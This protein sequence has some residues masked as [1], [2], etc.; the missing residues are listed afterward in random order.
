MENSII[1][2]IGDELL[3]G[4]TVDTNS[5]WI[6]TQMSKI[7][8]PVLTKY[9]VSD[10]REAITNAILE[11]QKHCD[12]IILTGGLGPTRDDITKNVLADYFNVD[13]VFN[14]EAWEIINNYFAGRKRI[15]SDLHRKQ[16]YLPANANLLEN[17]VGT[18]PGMMFEERGKLI[19]S[20]P[21]VPYEMEYIMKNSVLPLLGSRAVKT[22]IHKTIRTFGLPEST[23]AESITHIED[24]LPSGMGIAYLPSLGEVKLRISYSGQ[25]G[26]ELNTGLEKV[27]QDIEHILGDAVY[28]YDDDSLEVVVSDILH[29]GKLNLSLAESCTGGTL[30]SRIVALSGSAEIFEGGFVTYSNEMKEKILGVSKESLEQYGAVSEQV[31]SEM[32][33]GLLKLTGT[34][35][36]ISITGIAGPS[37]GSEHK[38]V[39]TVFIGVGTKERKEVKQFLFS[40]NRNVNIQIFC[41]LALNMLRKFLIER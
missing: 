35:F 38:P 21:G 8:C 40:K 41:N 3:L 4:Q 6:G 19:F 10:S 37:G 23:I 18:A 2:A 33:D 28:G 17:K 7:G 9:T 34:D 26:E 29:A 22:V 30:A 39:G 16:C 13:L 12:V 1:I 32:L 27:V 5:A 20:L 24:E 14:E 31:A 15:V 36:G 25:K 11:A